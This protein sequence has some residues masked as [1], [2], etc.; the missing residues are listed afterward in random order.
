MM[1]FDMPNVEGHYVYVRPILVADLPEKLRAQAG[2]VD[3]I[4]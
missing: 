4:Y 3:T 2:E 1:K